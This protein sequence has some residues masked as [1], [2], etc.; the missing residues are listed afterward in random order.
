MKLAYDKHVQ[1]RKVT[2]NNRQADRNNK[3]I[4]I[5]YF[6]LQNCIACPRSEVSTFFYKIKLNTYNLTAQPSTSKTIS[7]VLWTEALS[8]KAGNDLACTIYKILIRIAFEHDFKEIFVERLV[9]STKHK[10]FNFLRCSKLYKNPSTIL[11][12]C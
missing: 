11:T 12:T 10:F 6:D 4:P 2:Q 3:D 8:G 7:C 1:E 5:V 9:Y